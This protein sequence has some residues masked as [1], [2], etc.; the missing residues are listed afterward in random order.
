MLIL[1]MTV[2]FEEIDGTPCITCERETDRA[3]C[4]MATLDEI[5]EVGVGKSRP[6][7]ESG[8]ERWFYVS[9]AFRF[10]ESNDDISKLA[11]RPNE[12]G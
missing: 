10:I 6:Q 4:G 2:H 3:F 9:T 11:L 1:D 8:I 12:L 5:R 7:H